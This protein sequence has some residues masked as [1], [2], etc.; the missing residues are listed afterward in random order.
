MAKASIP[1]LKRRNSSSKSC[2]VCDNELNNDD[3]WLSHIFK[4]STSKSYF[5]NE[6]MS[7]YNEKNIDF[8]LISFIGITVAMLPSRSFVNVCSTWSWMQVS[9]KWRYF[10]KVN[11]LISTEKF[12]KIREKFKEVKIYNKRSV[13]RR[14]S[15]DTNWNIK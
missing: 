5:E 15:R 6:C 12:Q 8:F 13:L 14:Q 11:K 7:G 1:W 2:I 3:F 9:M 10:I 4:I